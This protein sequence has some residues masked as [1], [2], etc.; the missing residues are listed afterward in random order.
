MVNEFKN[1]LPYSDWIGV[2]HASEFHSICGDNTYF[3]VNTGTA[4]DGVY[5]YIVQ[6]SG[7]AYNMKFAKAKEHYY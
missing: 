5:V 4:H 7:G 1:N 3:E 2:G 6:T